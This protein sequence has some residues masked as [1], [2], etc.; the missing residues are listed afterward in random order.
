EDNGS[1]SGASES[2]IQVRPNTAPDGEGNASSGRTPKVDAEKEKLRRLVAKR[3]RHDESLQCSVRALKAQEALMEA[4]A[5]LGDNLGPH[6]RTTTS[7]AQIEAVRKHLTLR[8]YCPEGTMTPRT[9]SKM[10]DEHPQ[11]FSSFLN[12]LILNKER[13]VNGTLPAGKKL[14]KSHLALLQAADEI[15]DHLSK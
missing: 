1:S 6:G 14:V 5:F 10:Q 12:N 7:E 9:L 2:G 3:L 11:F 4:D 13:L 8:S 15:H